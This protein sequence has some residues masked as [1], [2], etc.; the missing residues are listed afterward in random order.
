MYVIPELLSIILEGERREKV[1]KGSN[2]ERGHVR[3]TSS[4]RQSGLASKLKGDLLERSR[5]GEVEDNV[6]R[7]ERGGDVDACSLEGED[8]GGD[9]DL[10]AGILLL[11]CL[12]W[13]FSR[14]VRTVGGVGMTRDGLKGVM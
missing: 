5:L 11:V 1:I 3:F 4:G 10:E 12:D 13:H 2:A 14:I 6:T 7:Q 8:I 9:D